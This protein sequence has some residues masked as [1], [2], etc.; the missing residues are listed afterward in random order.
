M[1]SGLLAP[2]FGWSRQLSRCGCIARRARLAR[3]LSPS[4]S[5]RPACF[6]SEPRASRAGV[7]SWRTSP[8]GALGRRLARWRSLKKGCIAWVPLRTAVGRHAPSRTARKGSVFC[9]SLG[10]QAA[11][12]PA[13]PSRSTRKRKH[14]RQTAGPNAAQEAALRRPAAVAAARLPP[15][16]QPRPPRSQA[17]LASAHPARSRLAGSRSSDMRQP[18]VRIRR[19]RTGPLHARRRKP[20][21]LPVLRCGPGPRQETSTA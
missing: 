6:F 8:T 3:L 20:A 1:A 16:V 11:R 17:R 13:Q 18:A 15:G 19:R 9:A 2:G 21:I 5:S 10:W 4:S 12:A 14:R 7:P